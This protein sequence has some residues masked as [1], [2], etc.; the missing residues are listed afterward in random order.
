MIMAAL[1]VLAIAV[2]SGRVGYTF[3]TV[4]RLR[5]WGTSDKAAK[6]PSQAAEATQEWINYL[7]PDVVVTEQLD[8]VCRKGIKSKNIIAAIA[9]TAEHNYVL[10]VSVPR[11]HDYQSK[12]EEAEALAIQY[13][14]LR[15]WVPA[16][17]RFFDNE[18]RNT[19][20]FEALSMALTVLRS[21][22]TQLA[23]AMG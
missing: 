8:A 21:P 11:K 17:R 7:K 6:S 19:V 5:D 10:D 1:R 16:K 23:A 9:R 2:A 20:I 15:D 13:P 14:D 22:S 4:D 3:L 18:P 12:Y